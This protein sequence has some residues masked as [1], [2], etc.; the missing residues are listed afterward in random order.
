MENGCKLIKRLKTEEEGMFHHHYHHASSCIRSLCIGYCL[1]PGIVELWE[2]MTNYFIINIL[3]QNNLFHFGRLAQWQ[4]R[5]LLI[6][7]SQIRFSDMT[8]KFSLV[9]NYSTICGLLTRCFC[10]SVSFVHFLP[11]AVFVKGP[12]M[13]QSTGQLRSFNC[14]RVPICGPENRPN[15][16]AMR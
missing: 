3:I 6:K 7:Q 11:C 14:I 1:M 15:P 9:E 4:C 2:N 8:W 10:V 5:Y 12:C 13:L 16:L